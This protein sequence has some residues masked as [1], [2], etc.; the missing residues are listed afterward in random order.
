MWARSP[1]FDRDTRPR[2][3]K[4]FF[5]C[6]TQLCKKFAPLINLKL[7]T[8]AN[9]FFPNIAEDINFAANIYELLLIFSYLLAE[10]ISCSAEMSMKKVI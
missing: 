5:S 9:Y 8:I 3:Y 1:F 4:T 6:S 10:K 2:G 7:L